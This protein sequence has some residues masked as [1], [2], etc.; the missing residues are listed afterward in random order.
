[1]WENTAAIPG[2]PQRRAEGGSPFFDP[3]KTFRFLLTKYSFF[4]LIK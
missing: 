2:E 1:M 4:D 3:E